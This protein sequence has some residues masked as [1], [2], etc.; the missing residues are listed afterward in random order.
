MRRFVQSTLAALIAAAFGSAAHAGAASTTWVSTAT[1]APEVYAASTGDALAPAEEVAPG[2]AMH[3]VVTL[4]LRNRA[5]L[6][7]RVARIRAGSRGDIIGSAQAAQLY[8]P[9]PAQ[10][11]AVVDHLTQAGFRN[12]EVA[13]NRLVI[14]ADGSAANATQ[15]FHTTLRHF[16]SGADRRFA[17]VTAAQVPAH[18]GS[19]VLAVHGLQNAAG[20]HTMAHPLAGKAASA[21]HSPTDF[22]L[23]YDA[24]SMPPAASATL[25]IISE[26]NL[27][28]TLADLQAFETKAGYAP[29]DAVVDYVGTKGTDT[30]GTVEWNLDSQDSLAAA[31]GA[32]K[33]MIFYAATSLQDAPLTQAYNQAVADNKASVINVSL[34]ECE[35]AAK[36]SGIEASNDQIF[37]LGVAQGQTFSVSSGDSGSQECGRRRGNKQSYPAVSPYVMSIGGTTLAGS[38]TTYAGETVWSGTGGGASVTEAAPSWQKSAGVLGSSTMR[39]VPD[40]AFDAD[41]ATGAIILVNGKNEQVGGTSLAAPLF[42]GFWARVQAANG[43]ALGFPDPAIYQYA[44]ANPSLFHDVTSGSNGGYSAK[45]GWDYTTGWGSLDVAKFNAFVATHAGF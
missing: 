38:G 1:G 14:S 24:S 15:A 20:F 25:A 17:N 8:L 12:I 37:A 5:D 7:A 13:S 6:D 22:P 2:E 45:A 9:T 10:V 11:K 4:K 27:D 21:G 31:G 28:P 30:S 33:Q 3:V 18:L 39:G 23:I 26:G 43:N 29:V 35:T 41:P 44:G 42:A 16:G 36:R 40:V 19:I 32:L 34:G